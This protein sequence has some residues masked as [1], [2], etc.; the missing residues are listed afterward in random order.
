M[1]CKFD[2]IEE[3]WDDNGLHKKIHKIYKKYFSSDQKKE[4]L[5][6]DD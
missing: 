2:K 5:T 1:K 4:F 6:R 3:I